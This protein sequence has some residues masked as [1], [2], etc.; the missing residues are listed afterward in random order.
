VAVA[1]L[2]LD[3]PADRRRLVDVRDQLHARD[4]AYAPGLWR[5]RMY[6]L[7]PT[8][9][10]ALQHLVTRALVATRGGDDVGRLVVY[11]DLNHDLERGPGAGWFACFDAADATAARALFSAGADWLRARGC[12]RAFGPWPLTQDAEP[13]L[14]A[15]PDAGHPM[16]GAADH[17]PGY[18]NLLTASGLTVVRRRLAMRWCLTPLGLDPESA[19]LLAQSA[20]AAATT[21]LRVRPVDTRRLADEVPALAQAHADSRR[22]AWGRAPAPEAAFASDLHELMRH[23]LPELCLVAEWRGRP[24]GM[25]LTLPDLNRILPRSGRLSPLA[26]LRLPAASRGQ[27]H[28]RLHDLWVTPDLADRGVEALLVAE[29]GRIARR[30]GL[31]EVETLAL[32]DDAG[33]TRQALQR[34]GAAPDH[35]IEIWRLNVSRPSTHNGTS[36]KP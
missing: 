18:G 15:S 9:N 35:A 17:S 36:A 13:G 32:D 3:R 4:P 34:G 16:T 11:Q 24:V 30:L 27:G 28:G 33:A 19:R 14:Q 23:A 25:A 20:E 31:L 2:A 5:D 22:D 1:A 7:D 29:T 8:R 10:P 26:R 12:R 6:R 21:Q